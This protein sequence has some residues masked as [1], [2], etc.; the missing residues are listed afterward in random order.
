MLGNLSHLSHSTSHFC[1]RYFQCRSGE[2]FAQAASQV[3]RI[4]DGTW[5]IF[6][7]SGQ[8]YCVLIKISIL[9]QV[10]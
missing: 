8:R 10:W 6:L 5:L 3:A 1:I 2:L 4:I 7:A 9:G